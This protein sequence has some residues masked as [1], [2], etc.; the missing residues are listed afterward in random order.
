MAIR[1]FLDG[2]R[3]RVRPAMG[4]SVHRHLLQGWRPLFDRSADRQGVLSP[5]VL[6]VAVRSELTAGVDL[7]W[8]EVE[9]GSRQENASNEASRAVSI[10]SK[11]RSRPATRPAE[12]MSRRVTERRGS[13]A[14]RRRR[15]DRKTQS[16]G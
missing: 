15:K 3:I 7:A 14:R 2:S 12:A 1:L 8:S 6:A 11:R 13:R 9:T 4:A 10:L 16:K 5:I